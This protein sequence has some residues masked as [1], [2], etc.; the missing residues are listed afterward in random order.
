MRTSSTSEKGSDQ[1]VLVGSAGAP[2]GQPALVL[3][4]ISKRFVIRHQTVRT[5][6]DALINLVH[7]TTGSAEDFWAVRNVTL[8]L[9]RGKTLGII[10]ENGSGKST[11]LKLITRI[12]E[13]TSGRVEVNGR[14]SALIELGAGFHP[15]L[16]GRENIYLNGSIL[17]IDRRAMDRKFDEIVSFSELERFIDTP[18]KHYSSGMY[19]RLGFSVAIAV[20]PDILI[21]DE[22]LSVGDESFQRKCGARINEFRRAGKTII[23]VSHDLRSIRRMCDHVLWLQHGVTRGAGPAGRVIRQYLSE[24]G[25]PEEAALVEEDDPLAQD[26]A[27]RARPPSIRVA[28]PLTS[29][30]AASALV[31]DAGPAAGSLTNAS[32]VEAI[33]SPAASDPGVHVGGD[34]ANDGIAEAVARIDSGRSGSTLA[35]A[36]AGSSS[37]SELTADGALRESCTA[38]LLGASGGEQ[39]DISCGESLVVALDY[40]LAE[41]GTHFVLSLEIYDQSGRMLFVTSREVQP[42]EP[43]ARAGRQL[44]EFPRLGLPAGHYELAPGVWRLDADG[45]AYKLE[46]DHAHMA[47]QRLPGQAGS[48]VLEHSWHDGPEESWTPVPPDALTDSPAEGG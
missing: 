46:G 42:L 9:P 16:S 44:V 45:E 17:G 21:V 24:V 33:V 47:L 43:G 4:D 37:S 38:E 39:S 34:G 26:A 6:Q 13:P 41:V 25:M 27:A 23:L 18:V 8:V 22:V 15:D 40:R 14:V 29:A 7:R 30:P 5:F 2:A 20:D 12:L 10:G 11:I 19:A 31:A 32:H 28:Q 48:V 35:E 36:A 1:H 3:E